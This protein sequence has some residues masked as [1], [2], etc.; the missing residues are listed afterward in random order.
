[1]SSVKANFVFHFKSA[2]A[3]D[4]SIAT[5]NGLTDV[6]NYNYIQPHFITINM[7]DSEFYSNGTLSDALDC[8]GNG[9][10][11]IV[12]GGIN[13]VYCTD[14]CRYYRASS[15]MRFSFRVNSRTVV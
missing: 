5:L 14:F 15:T 3:K 6:T 1:M 10:L 7:P 12:V 11:N 4:F 13:Y 2:P 9:W 8:T